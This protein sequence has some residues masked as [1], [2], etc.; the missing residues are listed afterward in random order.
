MTSKEIRECKFSRAM[1]GYKLEEVDNLL[2]I[3]EA[4]YE[5]FEKTIKE[6]NAKTEALNKEVEEYK[7]SQNSIQNVLLNAQKLADQI[8]DD[9]KV[10]AE[11]II[12]E[13]KKELLDIEAKKEEITASID[14]DAQ[15]RKANVE[16]EIAEVLTLANK[17]NESISAATADSVTRQQM[18][19]D[20]LKL[21]VAEFKAAVMKAYKEHL[22]IINSLPDEVP[23]DPKYVAKI[24]TANLDKA[25]EKKEII[26]GAD[27][28]D[29]KDTE[30]EENG[31]VVEEIKEPEEEEA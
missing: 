29:A 23:M 22:D 3:V 2:D 17:K 13:A 25:P 7:R 1:S 28:P 31:F 27:A 10:Q 12:S 21:E 16:K 20:K 24:I 30:P 15:I 19:F 18:L 6:I 11:D 4:D 14:A 8:I 9:A 26:K 5:R